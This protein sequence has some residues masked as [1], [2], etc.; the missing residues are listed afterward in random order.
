MRAEH[1]ETGERRNPRRRRPEIIPALRMRDRGH[2]KARDQK[3]RVIFSQHG[4]R[5]D[6]ARGD[7][8]EKRPALERSQE[9]ICRQRP[10]GEEHRVG[11]ET[12]GVKLIGGQQQQQQQDDR[13]AVTAHEAAADEIDAPHRERRVDHREQI[14]RPVR[15]RKHAGPDRRH[16]SH[17][18]RMLGIAPCELPS[19]RP[20]FK[21]IGVKIAA[22][23]GDDEIRHP[24]RD[25]ADQQRRNGPAALDPVQPKLDRTPPAGASTCG[26]GGG[27]QGHVGKSSKEFQ[28]LL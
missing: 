24:D 21:N 16:P 2:G 6:G 17:Q 3:H 8:P 23:I 9:A 26:H 5:S 13:P 27:I 22:P 25:K 14:E 10:C 20:C 18:R 1:G 12:L 19:D 11:I 7:R 28:T 4:Q 15:D